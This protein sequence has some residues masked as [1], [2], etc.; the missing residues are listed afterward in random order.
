MGKIE[1]VRMLSA[2]RCYRDDQH[3]DNGWC[4]LTRAQCVANYSS[5]YYRCPSKGSFWCDGYSDCP[6]QSDETNCNRTTL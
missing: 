1:R 2:G 5:Y 6:D 3:C 4:L